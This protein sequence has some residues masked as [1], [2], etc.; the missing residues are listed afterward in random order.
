MIG[1]YAPHGQVGAQRLI[2]LS[3]YLRNKGNDVSVLCLSEKSLKEIDKDSLTASIPDGVKIITYDI[4]TKCNSIMKKNI[5]N[6]RECFKAVKKALNEDKYDVIFISGGPF[7]SFYSM[8]EARRKNIPY[9]VDYRDLHLS[10]PDK[11]KRTKIKDKIKFLLSYPARF[12]QEYNCI[13]R[14]TKITV[15]SPEMK[16]NI[17]NYFHIKKDK[18]EVIYNGYDDYVLKNI[19][20]EKL[21]NRI[22]YIG[23]F[24]KL[25]YYKKDYSIMLF[26]AIERLNNKGYNIKLLHIGPNNQEI[27]VLL[28]QNNLNKK[29][30]YNYIG[31]KNYV[32][33]MS[34][35]TKCNAYYIEYD[36]PEGPGTKVFDYIFLNKPI[37]AIIRPHISLERLLNKFENAFIC[38]NEEDIEKSILEIIER[39]LLKLT[40][41]KDNNLNDYSRSSQNKKV[42]KILMTLE[43]GDKNE[44]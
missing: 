37:I 43:F 36:M 2:S 16:D 19:I 34:A 24:G 5:I 38:Y 39:K 30:W 12:F 27:D 42:E 44:K 1:P 26:N 41:K 17:S 35:L 33:G 11:R 25:M 31:Q 32:E 4:T 23:Y 14:A 13:R 18:I 40:T 6:E 3:R 22:F 29:N 8:K 15:V 21:D 10:S 20:E 28:K 9:I 7:Y